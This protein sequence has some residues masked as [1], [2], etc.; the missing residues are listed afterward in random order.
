MDQGGW[1]GEPTTRYSSELSMSTAVG[2]AAVVVSSRSE[3]ADVQF[4]EV[5]DVPAALNIAGHDQPGAAQRLAVLSDRDQDILVGEV[6]GDLTVRNRSSVTI[7]THGQ[8]RKGQQVVFL[9]LGCQRGWSDKLRE[10]HALFGV[11]LGPFVVLKL[12]LHGVYQHP[13][14]L[15]DRDLEGVLERAGDQHCSR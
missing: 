2:A 15:V 8:Y 7:S 13:A 14:E 11:V 5:A 3:S 9:I 6:R 12:N 10:Q 1:I 4:D